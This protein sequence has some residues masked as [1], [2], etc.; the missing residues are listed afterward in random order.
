M[1]FVVER[2]TELASRRRAEPHPAIVLPLQA[3]VVSLELDDGR[4]E[5]LD[6]ASL[7]IIPAS[8]RYRLRS[9]SPLAELVTLS[10]GPAVRASAARDYRGHVDPERF[11]ELLSKV[12]V[13][14][15]TRWVDE[16]V[17]RYV[18]ERDVCGKPRSR[19]AVFLEIEITKEIYFL[20]KEREEQRTRASVVREEGDLVPR[21]RAFIDAHLSD[22]LRVHDLAK[23]CHSSESTLLRAFARELGATPGSYARDRRLEASLL[24]LQAGRYSVTEVAGRVGY[25]SLPAF[26]SAFRRRFGAPPSSVRKGEGTLELLPPSG[27]PPSPKRKKRR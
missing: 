18:F 13:L 2:G 15:R 3:S 20:C 27:T 7:A 9:K 10:L 26:T 1:G 4:E 17:H 25:T 12:R 11:V 23:H 8:R 16:V 14:P 21:A 6:R 5:R 22:P 19:A 24:L